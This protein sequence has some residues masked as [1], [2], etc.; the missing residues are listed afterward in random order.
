M[1]VIWEKFVKVWRNFEN[2]IENFKSL[3]ENFN[4][5]LKN[6]VEFSYYRFSLLAEAWTV[7]HTLQIFW[8][9][10]GGGERS[11]GSPPLAPLLVSGARE[12]GRNFK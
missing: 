3:S 8:G 7:P 12:Q 5:N 2:L 1:I 11:P 10:G 6:L 9:F 4:K